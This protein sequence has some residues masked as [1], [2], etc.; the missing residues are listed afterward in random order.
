MAG[1]GDMLARG[2]ARF[3]ARNPEKRLRWLVSGW[4]RRLVLGA[5]FRQMP[6]RLNREQAKDVD[7]VIDW[8]I[9]DAAGERVDRYQVTIK[10]GRCRVSRRASDSPRSMIEV[11]AVDFLRLAA[12]LAQGPELFM[13]GK[14]RI[15]GD[16][17]FTARL[18]SLFRVPAAP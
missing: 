8:R 14:I 15:E 12:G 17:M 7:A 2:F 13:T 11:D 6:R 3:V 1:P 9:K 10:D 5:I 18:A 16:V 4:R